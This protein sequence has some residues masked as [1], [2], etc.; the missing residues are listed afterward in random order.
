MVA[1]VI[2][3]VMLILQSLAYTLLAG[4]PPEVGMYDNILQNIA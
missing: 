1:D 3:T 2:V 4:L